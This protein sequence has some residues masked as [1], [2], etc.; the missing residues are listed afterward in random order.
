MSHIPINYIREY[1]G[2]KRGLSG[3]SM[4]KFYDQNKVMIGMYLAHEDLVQRRIF[5]CKASLA[6][7]QHSSLRRL[8][9]S[10]VDISAFSD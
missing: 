1:R 8:N 6:L 3:G 4:I 10:F 7:D 2:I 9:L 5:F